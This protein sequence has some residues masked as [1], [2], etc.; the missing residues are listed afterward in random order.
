MLFYIQGVPRNMT[1]DKYSCLSYTVS[2]I[3]VQ[4]ILLGKSFV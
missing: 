2:D 4:F 1:V 3:K